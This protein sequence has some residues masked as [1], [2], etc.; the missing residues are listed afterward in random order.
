MTP[1][2]SF[3]TQF[4]DT[5]PTLPGFSPAPS[6]AGT[7]QQPASAGTQATADVLTALTNPVAAVGSGAMAGAA[8]VAGSAV[9][10]IF[11]TRGIAIILGL[12]LISGS[13]ILFF[14]DE[15]S[16]AVDKLGGKVAEAAAV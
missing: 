5:L 14:G 6:S 13:V 1:S 2:P 10:L 4:D 12:I 15:L 16:D 11:G 3:I 7:A 9:S 8:K